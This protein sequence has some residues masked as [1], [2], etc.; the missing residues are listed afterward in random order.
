[1]SENTAQYHSNLNFCPVLQRPNRRRQVH[2]RH[3]WPGTF[4]ACGECDPESENLGEA[5]RSLNLKRKHS[6]RRSKR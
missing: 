3:D 1:M 5:L 4:N 2:T 6:Q